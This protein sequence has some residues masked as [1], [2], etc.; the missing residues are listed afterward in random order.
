M[1][2]GVELCRGCSEKAPQ[3]FNGP[4]GYLRMEDRFRLSP[5]V[6]PQE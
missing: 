4:V 2:A 1:I 3:V 6:M 5:L